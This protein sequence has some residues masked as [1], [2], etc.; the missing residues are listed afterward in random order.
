ME[1]L[2]CGSCSECSVLSGELSSLTDPEEDVDL[3]VSCS[4]A[5]GLSN[6]E[7]IQKFSLPNMPANSALN[8]QG[9][10]AP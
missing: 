2:E 1:E 10:W 4:Q 3:Q 6:S 5:S 7:E 9:T 8:L